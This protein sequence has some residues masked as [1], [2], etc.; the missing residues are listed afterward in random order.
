MSD[1]AGKCRKSYVDHPKDRSKLNFLIHG[2][3]HTSD[4]CYVLGDFG[5]K[6]AKCMPTKY[7][8]QEPAINKSLEDRK[9]II[10]LSKIKLIRSSCKRRKN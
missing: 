1:S 8:S 3:G 2:P 9:R 4:E 10:I 7:R 5:N 6:Y